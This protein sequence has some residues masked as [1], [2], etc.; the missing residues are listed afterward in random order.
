MLNKPFS[1]ENK[2]SSSNFAF[3][4]I[5]KEY[6]MSEDYEVT[7]VVNTKTNMI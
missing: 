5:N 4:I 7:V 2:G 3:I 6:L 1:E